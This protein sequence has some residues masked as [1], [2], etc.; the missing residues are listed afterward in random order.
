MCLAA[1]SSS[2]FVVFDDKAKPLR[3][4]RWSDSDSSET[5]SPSLRVFSFRLN[6][7]NALLLAPRV[8]GARSHSRDTLHLLF[9]VRGE[10]ERAQAFCHQNRSAA[11]AM[12]LK[13]RAGVARSGAWLVCRNECTQKC[14]PR[15]GGLVM[16]KTGE[17][18][19]YGGFSENITK[20]RSASFGAI[21]AATGRYAVHYGWI[22]CRIGHW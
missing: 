13:G 17:G 19:V 10:Q 9:S 14:W 2:L 22:Q 20:K 15:S 18:S 8:R 7:P 4:W 11:S 1:S 5:P 12:A 6:H 3:E 21:S 16:K